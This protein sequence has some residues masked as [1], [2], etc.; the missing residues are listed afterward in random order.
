MKFIAYPLLG[1]LI[2]SMIY[3]G[4]KNTTPEVPAAGEPLSQETI[5]EIDSLTAIL[6]SEEIIKDTAAAQQMITL[7]LDASSARR[8]NI[9]LPGKI[10][11]AAEA[12][13][14]LKQYEDGLRLF[15]NLYQNYPDHELA[16]FALFHMGFT[17]D[18]YIGDKQKA[19]QLYDEFAKAYPKHEFKESIDQL[20]MYIEK[21]PEEV[22]NTLLE[23]GQEYIPEED[24]SETQIEEQ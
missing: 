4:S 7:M 2:L 10:R 3:C 1:L 12:A 18:N 6:G 24:T 11:Q 13:M 8:D 9:D 17:Y 20:R 5:K 22:F 23:R 15:E 19:L 14:F 21:T 16:A